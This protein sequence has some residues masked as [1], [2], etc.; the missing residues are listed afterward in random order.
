MSND[1]KLDEALS[2]N[3][4]LI[5]MI[6]ETITA[7][8][9]LQSGY[10]DVFDRIEALELSAKNEIREMRLEIERLKQGKP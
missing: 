10:Q 7:L 5:T 8:R 3:R 4:E 9:S 6:Q 1:N 2:L